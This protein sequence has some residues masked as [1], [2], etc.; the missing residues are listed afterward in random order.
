MNAEEIKKELRESNTDDLDRRRKIIFLSAVGLVDFSIISL[1]QTGVIKRLPDIPLAIF[2][3]NKVNASNEAYQF[4]VPDGPVSSLTYAATMVLA[5]AKGTKRSGRKP[6]LDVV[7][8]ATV[9]ANAIG[10]VSYLN[11]MIFKQ[12]KICLYCVTGAAIN[13]ASAV[14]AAPIVLKSLKK[15]LRE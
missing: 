6:L 7:L 13:I 12:K 10:A 2:D 4:G 9:A 1:Y 14:I 15:L 5:A 8:G 11:N 3:S